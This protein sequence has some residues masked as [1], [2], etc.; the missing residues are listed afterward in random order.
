MKGINALLLE[1]E[2]HLKGLGLSKGT[3]KGYLRDI[4]DFY[5]YWQARHSPAS[6][7]ATDLRDVREKDLMEY[8]SYL[9]EKITARGKPY[10]RST[11]SRKVYTVAEFFKWLYTSEYIL[12]NPAEE[13]KL[14]MVRDKGKRGIF[15]K[16][17]MAQFLDSISIEGNFGQRN[18]ALFELLYSS[19]LRMGE[20]VN[21]NMSDIGLQERVLVVLNGKGGKDRFVPF[22]EVALKFLKLYLDSERKRL[23]RK[24][25]KGDEEA[26][27][28]GINGRMTKSQVWKVFAETMKKAGLPKERNGLP[29]TCHSIRHSCATHLLEAGADVRYVSE[30]LGHTDIATTTVYTHVLSENKRKA[31]KSAHPRENKYYEEITEEYLREVDKLHDELLSTMLK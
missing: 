10:K 19:G 17:E 20:A 5:E 7:Y 12:L 21:L 23:Q 30:L 13:L 8:F 28:L 9:R 25:R 31:Y 24:V 1:F 22:S 4:R 2:I 15:T 16:E 29:R 27:F 14:P 11:A 26:V 18:R 3:E 6:R